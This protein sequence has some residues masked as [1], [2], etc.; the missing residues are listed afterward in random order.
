[1]K[2]LILILILALSILFIGVRSPIAK[3]DQRGDCANYCYDQAEQFAIQCYESTGDETACSQAMAMV[4][5]NCLVR[6]CHI[7]DVCE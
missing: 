3:A 2:R 7:G 5:C 1:M 4:Q 6:V